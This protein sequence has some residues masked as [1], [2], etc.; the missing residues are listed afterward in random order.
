MK[1]KFLFTL[2]LSLF[3]FGAA[4]AQKAAIKTNLLY[5]V[6]LSPN[7]GVELKL[8][9]KWTFDLSGNLNAW[10]VDNKRWKHWLV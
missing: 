1:I 5:D 2:I 6:T 3:A 9:P 10:A 8:A 7:L 4:N